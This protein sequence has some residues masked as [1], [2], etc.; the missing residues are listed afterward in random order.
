MPVVEFECCECGRFI[1]S[2]AGPAPDPLLCA[3]C[4]CI[5]GW[6]TDP[7]VAQMIDPEHDRKAKEDSDG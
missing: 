6:F 2:L 4:M 3:A 5:P 1:I 7:V